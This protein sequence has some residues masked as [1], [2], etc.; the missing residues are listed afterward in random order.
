MKRNAKRF[1]S[2]AVLAAAALVLLACG[3]NGEDGPIC[4]GELNPEAAVAAR[5]Y[6]ASVVLWLG[7]SFQD[8]H[9]THTEPL[10]G[11]DGLLLVYGGCQKSLGREGG[12][13]PPLQIQAYPPGG[14]PEI[15]R[16]DPVPFRGIDRTPGEPGALSASSAV[17]WL[18]NGDTI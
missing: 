10:N 9:L 4:S 12:S 7:E 3:R 1:A 15:A 18:P 6:R 17:L 13:T 16:V 8:L 2:S 14:I 5:G 11:G